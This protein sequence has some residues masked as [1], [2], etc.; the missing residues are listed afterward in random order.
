M[1]YTSLS[2]LNR[3]EIHSKW[4][5]ESSNTIDMTREAQVYL[6]IAILDGAFSPYIQRE[7]LLGNWPTATPK[8]PI[9]QLVRALH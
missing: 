1:I 8:S 7:I 3:W 2:I 4:K 6:H 9:A 5:E